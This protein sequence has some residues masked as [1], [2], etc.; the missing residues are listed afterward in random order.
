MGEGSDQNKRSKSNILF[1]F[2]DD[3][4][5]SAVGA[6]ENDDVKTPNLDK[7]SESGIT[8]TH[9]FNMGGWNGA[10]CLASRAMLNT[11]RF[12]WRAHHVDRRQ[13]ELVRNE[14]MWSQIMKKAGYDTYMSGKWHVQTAPEV[15]FDT[16]AHVRGGMPGDLWNGKIYNEVRQ[17]LSEGDSHYGRSMPAG[18]NRPLSIRDTGWQPW[19]ESFGGYWEGGKH[20]SEV[21]ADDALSFLNKSE[22]NENPFFMYLAFNAPHDPRQSP[23]SFVEMYQMENIST[24]PAFLSEY[25]YK[26][27]VGCDPSLRDEALAPFP[28][29]EFAVKTHLREYYALITHMDEQIGKIMEALKAT[30]QIENTYIFFTADH[31]LAMGSHGFMGK[32]NMYDHSLR[33]PLFVTGPDL[34]SGEYFDSEVY[35]QDVVPT[36]L[37]LAGITPPEAYDFKSF[38]PIIEGEKSHSLYSAIYGAYE[39]SKQRMIRKDGFKLIVYPEI[40]TSRLYNIQED[41]YELEDLSSNE[42]YQDKIA[43]LLEALSKLQVDMDDPIN[44]EDYF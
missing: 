23:E 31:G 37:E 44:V 6:M 28:R 34:P 12:L 9:A 36:S 22:Q 4:A 38:L 35:L 15:L 42:D 3:L 33:V 24:P 26:D 2:A 25:P 18:Y 27:G 40:K 13:D 10:V 5:Y 30:G 20:W 39:N 32:Q 7:L 11:G 21:L 17:K 43:E 14:E 29:T 19:N 8:F 41:P 1:I 16:V